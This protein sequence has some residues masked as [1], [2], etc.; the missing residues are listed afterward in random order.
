MKKISTH[1]YCVLAVIS[2]LFIS[3]NSEA[4]CTFTS[5]DGYTVSVQITPVSLIVPS[6]C[7]NGYNYNVQMN[8]KVSFSGSNIP[9]AMYTLQG[10]LNCG[11]DGN[12]FSLPLNGGAGSVTSVSNPYRGTTD[13][14]SASTSSLNCNTVTIIAQGPGLSY[15]S[16]TC[17]VSSG[18]TLAVTLASFNGRLQGTNAVY[19]KWVS[20]TETNNRSYTVQRSTDARN[21]SSITT[22]NGAGNSSSSKEYT[23]TDANLS[24]GMYYYRLEMTDLNGNKTYSQVIGATITG[25]ATRDITI[26]P[27]P[28]PGNQ[29]YVSELGNSRD[30]SMTV[31][32]S[33]S[34][35]VY[36]TP[37]L[38][39]NIVQLPT[40][41]SGLYL[42]K[43]INKGT[44]KEKVLKFVKN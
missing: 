7:P 38:S 20:A 43:L 31:I 27:N 24:N 15:Q 37:S 28:N 8:Y 2:L 21:W 33:A 23:Y 16:S 26:G 9:S 18:G 32:N 19:L 40:L 6:S 41:P 35:I 4:Q 42:V 1:F 14:A 22:I 5:S 25:S 39:S 13:C 36:N 10:S 17:N 12:F 11:S 34:A 30:W 29:L 3:V 44:G